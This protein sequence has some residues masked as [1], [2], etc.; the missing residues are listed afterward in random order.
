MKGLS[1]TDP[2]GNQYAV[3]FQ[4]TSERVGNPKHEASFD[5]LSNYIILTDDLPKNTSGETSNSKN[6]RSIRV[7]TKEKNSM[8]NVAHEVGHTLGAAL[9]IDGKDNHAEE[10]LMVKYLSSKKRGNYLDQKSINEIIEMGNGPTEYS[11]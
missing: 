1:Y 8:F 10:G 2:S 7:S 3:S 5:Q 6:N 9:T 4:L 11:N